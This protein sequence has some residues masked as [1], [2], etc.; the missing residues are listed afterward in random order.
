MKKL[1]GLLFILVSASFGILAQTDQAEIR[2]L[3]QELNLS[4]ST[5]LIPNKNTNF[6]SQKTIKIFAAI[7]HNKSFAKD[8]VEWVGN[9]NKDKASQFGR[10]EIVD[11]AADADVIAAQFRYGTRK[12]VREEKI[13]ASTGK[14]ST[15]KNGDF[16]GLGIGNSKV[17]G[18]SGYEA[19]NFP[20]YSYLLVRGE[21]DSWILDFSYVD[22][23]SDF[24]KTFPEARL[25]GIIENKMM[26]R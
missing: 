19:V 24:K 20:L 16:V 12:Y 1:L 3:R 7:K 25:Q 26:K 5:A 13:S 17:K 10:L 18:E 23:A 6:P 8:F 22:D 9:W 4:K 14:I 11:K 15:D 2:Q 21:G